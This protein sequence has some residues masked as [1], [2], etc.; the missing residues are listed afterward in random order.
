[1]PRSKWEYPLG[2]EREYV[3]SLGGVIEKIKSIIKK[4]SANGTI[5][6]F[7]I[8]NMLNNY[9]SI[10]EPWAEKAAERMVNSVMR[11][12]EKNWST[13]GKRISTELRKEY[14]AAATGQAATALAAEQVALIKSLPMQAAEKVQA[15]AQSALINGER[16][17]AIISRIQEIGNIQYNRAKVIARTEISKASS[18]LTQARA[19]S[20]GSLGYIWRTAKDSDVRSSHKQMDGEYVLWSSPPRLSDGT[21]THAG[22]IY[23]CRCYAEPVFKDEV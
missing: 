23:N 18:T 3:A 20:A 10:L 17:A 15:L 21:I 16:S 14:A 8:A 11:R 1:M 5:D 22:Q 2:A 6:L 7:G 4:H 12:N 13:I 9:S 19:Q